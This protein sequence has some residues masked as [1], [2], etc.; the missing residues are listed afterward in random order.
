MKEKSNGALSTI[1]SRINTLLPEDLKYGIQEVGR[2][3]EEIK[4]EERRQELESKAK[5]IDGNR[6]K[7]IDDGGA[8]IAEQIN[9]EMKDEKEMA[10]LNM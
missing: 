3:L 7:D 2:S 8:K 1:A 4:K 6:V 5:I 10:E 9:E